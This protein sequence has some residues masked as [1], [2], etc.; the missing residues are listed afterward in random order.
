MGSRR[1]LLKNGCWSIKKIG[2]NCLKVYLLEAQK[3]PSYDSGSESPP[4]VHYQRVAGV[5][6][7][8]NCYVRKVHL[9]GPPFGLNREAIIRTAAYH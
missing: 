3:V 7:A 2:V 9:S 8:E 4:R 5:S 6:E 1:G